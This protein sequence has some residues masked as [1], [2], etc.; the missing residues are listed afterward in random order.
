NTTTYTYDNNGQQTSEGTKTF[1]YNLAGQL[2]QVANGGSTLASFTY[3][4]NGN[5]LTKTASSVTTDYR[6]DENNDLPMLALE[7][8]GGSTLRSYLYGDQLL[9]MNA[10]GASFYFHHDA[11]G[12]TS[13]ITKQTGATQWTYTY[14]PYGEAHTTTK[15]DPDAPDNPMRYTGALIDLEA[16]LYDLRAR[17][18]DPDAGRFLSTDPLPPD[19]SDATVSVYLYADAHPLSLTDPSGQRPA[20]GID[21][22]TGEFTAPARPHWACSSGVAWWTDSPDE[23]PPPLTGPNRGGHG[24]RGSAAQRTNADHE[25]AEAGEGNEGETTGNPYG[26]QGGTGAAS[27][28]AAG[29]GSG[30]AAQAKGPA[31]VVQPALAHA[32]A[33]QGN[34]TSPRANLPG[35]PIL[36]ILRSRQGGAGSG[37]ADHR[38][39][40]RRAVGTTLKPGRRCTRTSSMSVR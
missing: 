35:I 23:C 18:Y 7:Q 3:D 10:G 13:A 24:G 17:L 8:Q 5:R 40:G 34:P 28:G 36:E 33:R 14:T 38:K 39:A 29:G 31:A 37:E 30:G 26:A 27:G 9:S 25:G 21:S 15:V 22:D 4:G 32:A 12:T 1:T 11:L 6:W 16:G 2:T 19:I 20:D